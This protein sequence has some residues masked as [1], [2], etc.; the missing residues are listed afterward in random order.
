MVFLRNPTS[1][2][3]PAAEIQEMRVLM[4]LLHLLKSRFNGGQFI[5]D[6]L[7]AIISQVFLDGSKNDVYEISNLLQEVSDMIDKGLANGIIPSAKL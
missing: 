5:A 4:N 6:I 7:S 3:D 1:L 2:E